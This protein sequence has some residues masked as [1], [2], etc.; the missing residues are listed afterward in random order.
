MSALILERWAEHPVHG[1]FGEVFHNDRHICFTVERPWANNAANI[2]CIPSGIYR[3]EQTTR[4]DGSM[5]FALVNHDLNVYRYHG[6]MPD[7]TGRFAIL[8]HPA[9]WMTDVQ[10]CIGPG[11]TIASA[12]DRNGVSRMMVTRSNDTTERL[13]RYIRDHGIDSIAVVWKEH[14]R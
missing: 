7:S 13:F 9:N 6:D 8:I 2:S 12:P 14:M 4:M 1:A 3:L 11:E 5:A 10:G